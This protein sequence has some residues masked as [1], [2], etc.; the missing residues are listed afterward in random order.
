MLRSTVF[1]LSC[2]VLN[3]GNPCKGPLQVRGDST[4]AELVYGALSCE[5]CDADFPILEG[6]AVVVPDVRGYLLHHVKGISKFVADEHIPEDI[7]EEYLELKESLEEEHIEEDLE[8][9]RVNSLYLMNHY[10]HTGPG[11]ETWWKPAHGTGSPLLSDLIERYWDQ[12]PLSRVSE[13]VTPGASVVELGCGVGG[14][15]RRLKTKGVNYLG[16]DSAFLSVL[17]A[18]HMNLG[19]P[20]RGKLSH[21]FD[22]LQGNQSRPLGVEPDR[23]A[24]RDPSCTVDF[25]VGELESLPLPDCAFEVSISLNAIDMLDEP[26]GL[27]EAQKKHLKPGGVAI[28]SGPY[29][30]HEKVARGL[31]G[32]LPKGI[33]TSD[34]AVEWLYLKSGFEVKQRDAHIPWLFFK[35]SR[36][37][38]LYSVH[39]F[40]AVLKS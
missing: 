34:Q 30:W 7:R 3:K 38:E 19:T 11:S 39:A 12:G 20:Y 15:C 16:V 22:L 21:P 8:S 31:R 13:W 35:H 17:I 25:V 24:F 1:L 5:K 27:P 40:S 26:K 29:V 4:G 6:V 32:R 33:E 9:D 14:L 23:G 37:L 36:Q 2:P 28:Q 18:R 10:L